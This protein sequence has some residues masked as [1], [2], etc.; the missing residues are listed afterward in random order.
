MDV[1]IVFYLPCSYYS[2]LLLFHYFIS[3]SYINN[4][5]YYYI[6][7]LL[8]VK[9]KIRT[10]QPAITEFCCWLRPFCRDGST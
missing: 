6:I 10:D 9:R 1:N 5:Y 7:F 8:V 3:S 4:N 2:I